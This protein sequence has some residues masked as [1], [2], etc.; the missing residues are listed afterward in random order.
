MRGLCLW[1]GVIGALC[2]ASAASAYEQV[3][4]YATFSPD[5]LNTSTTVAFGLAVSSPDGTTPSPLEDL[6]LFLPAGLGLATSTLGLANCDPSLLLEKGISGCSVNARMGYGTA[7]A[8]VPISPEQVIEKA[9]ITALAG[10]PNPEHLELLFYAE[11]I[12]PVAAQ[13]VFPGRM[14]IGA[15]KGL[16]S[17][18]LD[19]TVPLVPTWP[20]GPDVSLTRLRSTI[21]PAGLTYT[22]RLHGRTIR[23]HPQ[24]IT[25]PSSCPRGGFRLEGIFTFLDGSS[26]RTK[27]TIPCPRTQRRSARG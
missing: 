15:P 24:G 10:P 16:Y 20:G 14:E 7:E 1:L 6:Q 4:L 18:D 3:H 8:V 9:T 11:A 26:V 2:C 21:G 22:R 27:T 17:G 23:F 5:R 25:I 13:L 12:S 19:T